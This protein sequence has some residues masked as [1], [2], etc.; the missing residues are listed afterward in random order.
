MFDEGKPKDIPYLYTITCMSWKRDGSRLTA[1]NSL[2]IFQTILEYNIDTWWYLVVFLGH[3]LWWCWVVWLLLEASCLQKQ[4]WNDIRRS[5]S[6]NWNYYEVLS[7][8]IWHTWTLYW[9]VIVK[10]LASGTRVI[11]K[12]FYGY[13]IDEVKIMGGDRY[14]VAHTSDTLMLGQ[15]LLSNLLLV[16]HAI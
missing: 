10:N 11:L 1:V 13:E 14:L 8:A 4:V 3:T 5:E 7:H 16:V 6:G 9:Q 12:S 15:C 2:F